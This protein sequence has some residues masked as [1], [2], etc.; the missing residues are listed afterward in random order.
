MERTDRKRK[1]APN[2]D[3][4][5]GSSSNDSDV[6]DLD[7]HEVVDATEL[8]GE[9]EGSELMPA[10]RKRSSRNLERTVSRIQPELK[11]DASD[12]S[13]AVL[14]DNRRRSTRKRQLRF[15]QSHLQE[16]EQ[17]S[18]PRAQ[19]EEDGDD[20]F[21][22]VV[23]DITV[24]K[25]RGRSARN[26]TRRL[27][28]RK[29]ASGQQGDS[30]IEFEQPRRSSRATRNVNYIQDD[31]DMDEDTF[32][33]V[34]EKP[35]GLLKVA[36]VK[37][38]FRPISPDSPFAKVHT[39]TC[40]A[41]GSSSNRSQIIYC[42]GCSYAYHKHCIGTRSAREHLVTKVGEADFVLQCRFCIDIHNKKDPLAPRRSICQTCKVAG[43]SCPPFSRRQTTRQ[44]E[45]LRE[46]NGGLDPITP[47]SA[48]LV[49]NA[50][51]VLFRCTSCNRGWHQ[52]HL[53]SI[54][55]PSPG[56]TQP[57]GAIKDYSIDWQCN[58][59]TSA[60]QKIHRLVAWRTNAVAPLA[61]QPFSHLCDDDREYLIKW[62]KTSYFH[63]T[64]MP[65]AWVFGTAAAAMRASFAK[66]ALEADLFKADEKQAIPE[67][68]LTI[69]IIFRVKLNPV[70]PR[71]DSMEEDLDNMSHITKALV[72]FQGLG[73]DDVVWDRP[74][75][76]DSGDLY[77]AFKLAY[78]E[79]LAG[80]Y[81]EHSSQ[82]RMRERIKAF[83]DGEL[84]EVEVQP[85]GLK[86]GK[87]MGYQLEG[88]NWLLHNFHAGRSVVLADEMGLGKTVQVVS[89]VVH[90]VQE[91]P[92]VSK[93]RL[94]YSIRQI[95]PT[96]MYTVLAIPYF[97]PE[98]NMPELA[99]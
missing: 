8:D 91:N 73:Y 76:R 85:A 50:A 16:M 68:Y 17:E 9:D 52:H 26:R 97:R 49:H 30:D 18:N 65:G 38:L 83:K 94:G 56:G 84:E 87:L 15:P 5:A 75:P 79:Y 44:E 12:D 24:S 40:H 33:R 88:L 1:Y 61:V 57:V 93:P 55:S 42:Q 60:E 20:H 69:D 25:G 71:V 3:W 58:E 27:Q 22:P 74:P 48:E 10:T 96:N 63:C 19:I 62:E 14:F 31:L 51:N 70:T 23:S 6:M 82:G 13:G 35:S 2:D 54:G 36:S 46:E 72:K 78:Q 81:F 99:S 95:H 98:C 64:W 4:E 37:E 21:M 32:T 47:V 59:C 67:E 11:M 45:K 53:P 86:R 90:L 34:D 89:L 41:C 43:L 29:T 77:E 66:K 80:K 28:T 39:D 7:G 92:K